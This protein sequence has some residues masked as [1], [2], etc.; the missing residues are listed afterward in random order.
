MFWKSKSTFLKFKLFFL[1]GGK[2]S[3]R[4]GGG[5]LPPQSTP[6]WVAVK[7]IFRYLKGT[8]SHGLLFNNDGGLLYGYSDAEWAGSREDRKSTSAYVMKI[9]GAAVAD[10]EKGKTALKQSIKHLIVPLRKRCF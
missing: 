4:G 8:I 6:L 5:K 2:E 10:Q 1:G 7:R 3:L 9:G